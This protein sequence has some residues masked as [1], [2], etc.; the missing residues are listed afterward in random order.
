MR[1]SIVLGSPQLTPSHSKPY[2]QSHASTMKD[3]LKGGTVQ[4]ITNNLKR[5]KPNRAI[6]TR[7]QKIGVDE[8]RKT[9][10]VKN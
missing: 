9:N 3:F 1:S 10:N 6:S 7:A 4:H 5:M 2:L 8:V